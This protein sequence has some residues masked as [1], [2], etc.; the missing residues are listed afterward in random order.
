MVELAARWGALSPEQQTQYQPSADVAPP[1]ARGHPPL[2]PPKPW[3]FV[4]DDFYPVC[5][6]S[7]LNVPH[8]VSKLDKAWKERV[9]NGVLRPSVRIRE[10]LSH[11]CGEV[12]GLGQCGLNIA[13]GQQQL[14]KHFKARL[15]TW[16][17][18]TKGG[19]ATFDG[20]WKPLAM[21]YVGPDSAVAADAADD[22]RG[23][24]LLLLSADGKKRSQEIFTCR[25]HSPKAGDTVEFGELSIDCMR[26]Q[27]DVARPAPDRMCAPPS[28]SQ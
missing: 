7:L 2:G 11:T 27:N 9:G 19:N 25:L 23:Y 6:E 14:L 8:E 12:W 4:A 21:F 1:A 10:T 18:L 3:P 15:G 28:P 13:I 16:F 17:T 20:V 24:A 22:T 5:Q 26:D